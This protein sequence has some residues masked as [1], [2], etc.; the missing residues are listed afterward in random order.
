MPAMGM[1]STMGVGSTM[2]VGS[3]MGIGSTMG[4]Y[5][6]VLNYGKKKDTGGK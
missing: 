6:F 1:G 3:T 2:C 5:F 4:T